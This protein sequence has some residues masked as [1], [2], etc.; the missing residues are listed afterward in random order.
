MNKH[1]YEI[2]VRPVLT[3]KATDLQSRKSPQYT[4]QVAIDST[5]VDIRKAIETA[6]KV[7]VMSVNTVVNKGKRKRLRT[8]KFGRRPNWKKAIITLAEG[9][10][11]NLV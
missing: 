1:P 8:A 3:E 11:I 4:F 10:S 9:Q 2:L 6:F 5:K 7:K